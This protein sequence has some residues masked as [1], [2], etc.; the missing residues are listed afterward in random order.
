[1][2]GAAPIDL[3]L[4]FAPIAP[5]AA[6]VDAALADIGGD[7]GPSQDSWARSRVIM[8]HIGCC[9]AAK[10]LYGEFCTQIRFEL[11]F[12]LRSTLCYGAD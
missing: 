11:Y 10:P 1:M 12:G 3:D 2:A 7:C 9:L 5:S 6:D 8:R 4:V